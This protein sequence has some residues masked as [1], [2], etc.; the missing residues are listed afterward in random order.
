MMLTAIL[1]KHVRDNQMKDNIAVH[2]IN[3]DNNI[4]SHQNVY[5]VGLVLCVTF[6]GLT[7]SRKK[8]NKNQGKLLAMKNNTTKLNHNNKKENF[9]TIIRKAY[10]KNKYILLF[11]H[12]ESYIYHIYIILM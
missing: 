6:K 2:D 10:L 1:E 8:S 4:L 12:I 11:Y 9:N 3:I 5:L 7:K